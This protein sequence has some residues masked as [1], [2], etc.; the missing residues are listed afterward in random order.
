MPVAHEN[1]K[2]NAAVIAL[3]RATIAKGR[4]EEA[5][6]PVKSSQVKKHTEGVQMRLVGWEK[7]SLG[8][9]ASA[10]KGRQAVGLGGNAKGQEEEE[11][12][13]RCG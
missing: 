5:S 10:A 1:A 12:D 7:Q 13:V 6:G 2:Y 9:D 11:D 3:K 8:G 4:M